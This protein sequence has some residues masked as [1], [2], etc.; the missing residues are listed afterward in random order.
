MVSG[1]RKNPRIF[2]QLAAFR[3]TTPPT[4]GSCLGMP[5]LRPPFEGSRQDVEGWLEARLAESAGTENGTGRASGKPRVLPCAGSPAVG[6][7]RQAE[8][9][10]GG[11][12]AGQVELFLRLSAEGGLCAPHPC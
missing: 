2:P 12:L 4:A 5:P 8:E 3:R 7:C 1:R 11:T 9:G 10:A 6:R